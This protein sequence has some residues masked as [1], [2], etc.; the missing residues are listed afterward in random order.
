MK[1]HEYKEMLK[2]EG[3]TMQDHI[4]KHI[5]VCIGENFG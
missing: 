2:K 1:I 5:R 4:T 3:T